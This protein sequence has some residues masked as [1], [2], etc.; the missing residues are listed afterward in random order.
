M[1]NTTNIFEQVFNYI[2]PVIS[3]VVVLIGYIWSRQ[4]RDFREWLIKHNAD[5][6]E[7]QDEREHDRRYVNEEIKEINQQMWHRDISY[8]DRLNE[9]REDV[10][11]IKSD[12]DNLKVICDVRH[13]R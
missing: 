2:T 5:I 11:G 12:V 1:D 4:I 6:K 9:T 13:N 8:N 3:F 7:L 10:R